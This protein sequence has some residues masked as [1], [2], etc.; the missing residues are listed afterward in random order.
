MQDLYSEISVGR[1]LGPAARI[2]SANGVGVDLQG[3]DAAVVVVETGTITDG[4]HTI[5]VQDSA[6]NT[7]FAA[8]AD[9][10]LKGTEPVIAAA[11]DDTVYEVGYF[12]IKRYIRAAVT[13]SG[14]TT[15]GVYGANVVRGRARKLPK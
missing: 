1:S 4:T 9:A 11:N 10:D 15:G 3:F 8:V 5:E 14:A 12:G 13:V 7:T 2:A 6:D